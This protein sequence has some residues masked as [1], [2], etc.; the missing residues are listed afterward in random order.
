MPGILALATPREL[1]LAGEPGGVPPMAAAAYRAASAAP[2]VEAYSG[3]A[4]ETR[5]RAAQW[6]AR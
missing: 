5:Q 4:D 6:L 2:S 3:P 1:F